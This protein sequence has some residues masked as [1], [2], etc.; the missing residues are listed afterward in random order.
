MIL[1]AVFVWQG[2][3]YTPPFLALLLQIIRLLVIIAMEKKLFYCEQA[4]RLISYLCGNVINSRE[5]STGKYM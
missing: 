5:I 4:S 3:T 1:S 2:C